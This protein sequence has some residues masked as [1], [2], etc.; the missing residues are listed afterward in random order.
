MESSSKKILKDRSRSRT[1]SACS[2]PIKHLNA[3]RVCFRPQQLLG[4]EVDSRP[5]AQNAIS[6]TQ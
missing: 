5:L 6:L 3:T 4:A 1:V 2:S